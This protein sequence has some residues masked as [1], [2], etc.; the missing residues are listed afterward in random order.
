MCFLQ[1]ILS[2]SKSSPTL[3]S[4]LTIGWVKAPFSMIILGARYIYPL[5]VIV[6]CPC[7]V[8]WVRN[9]LWCVYFVDWSSAHVWDREVSV[10]KYVPKYSQFRENR[11]GISS[12]LY[13]FK[14]KIDDRY[15]G[16]AAATPEVSLNIFMD[17]RILTTSHM[18]IPR[19]HQPSNVIADINQGPKRVWIL[20]HNLSKLI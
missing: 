3:A 10:C 9:D 7:A 17:L 15:L 16:S 4:I 19:S 18:Y 5:R 2:F 13:F 1:S 8:R 20:V 14:K 6:V 12:S 11:L